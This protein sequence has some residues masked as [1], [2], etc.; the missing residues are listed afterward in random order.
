[1]II[2]QTYQDMIKRYCEK[3]DIQY[4]KI[5]NWIEVLYNGEYYFYFVNEPIYDYQEEYQFAKLVEKHFKDKGKRQDK[6]WR[7]NARQSRA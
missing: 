2:T 7:R 1:M 6:S 4:K 3:K 5:R